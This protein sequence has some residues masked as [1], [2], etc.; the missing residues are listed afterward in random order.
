MENISSGDNGQWKEAT[1]EN[2][3]TYEYQL[4]N[5]I[6]NSKDNERAPTRNFTILDPSKYQ[7]ELGASGSTLWANTEEVFVVN[8]FVNKADGNFELDFRFVTI[9]NYGV[10]IGSYPANDYDVS[11]LRSAG[12]NSVLDI[13]SVYRSVDPKTEA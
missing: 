2:Q 5:K 9:D 10:T 3:I 11:Q 12:C 8:G 7:G 13:Q 6:R 1:T 4:T